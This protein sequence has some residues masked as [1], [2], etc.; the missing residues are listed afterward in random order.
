MFTCTHAMPQGTDTAKD[1]AFRH[2]LTRERDGQMAFG[3]R[4]EQL[5]AFEERQRSGATRPDVIAASDCLR[6]RGRCDDRAG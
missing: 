3:T 5:Q 1:A 4:Q 6:A 2:L